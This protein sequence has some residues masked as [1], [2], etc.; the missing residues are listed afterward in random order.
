MIGHMLIYNSSKVKPEDA[1]RTWTDLLDPKWKNQV[2][3]G[4]PAFS[5]CTGVWVVALRK[6]YGWSYFEKLAK[7]NPRVG[8]SGNDP[9]TGSA[10]TGFEPPS[11]VASI[12]LKTLAPP[13]QTN[14]RRPTSSQKSCRRGT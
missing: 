9:V 4:H 13:P 5:G 10:L 3:T 14:S 6:L 2:A 1:P 11:S 8:R 12:T 7:N